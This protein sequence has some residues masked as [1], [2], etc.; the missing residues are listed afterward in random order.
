MKVCPV[1]KREYSDETKFCEKDG[2]ILEIK[3]GIH[4]R[5]KVLI[6]ELSKGLIEKDE[7]VRLALLTAI[8]GESIFFLGA[9]GCA[10]SMIARRIVQAFKPDG[11]NAIKYFETLLNQ[12]TTPEEV[13]GN[14]S[15]KALNGELEGQNGKEEYRRLTEN[16]LPE[17]DGWRAQMLAREQAQRQGQIPG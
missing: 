2:S 8:A 13:F 7:A 3:G 9:P 16:M 17:A 11:D 5:I 12:F 15:L 14:I 10:K 6:Q 1:C 4:F